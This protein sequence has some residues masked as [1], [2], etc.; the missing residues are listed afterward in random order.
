MRRSILFLIVFIS[1]S[2]SVCAT[3]LVGLR[4]YTREISFTGFTR[5]V[6]EMTIA[7]EISGKC[8][9]VVVDV[10]DAVGPSGVVAEIDS[11]FVRL[12]LEKNKIAQE[13]TKLQLA[14]ANKTLAR[15]KNLINKNSTAQATY[16][17]TALNAEVLALNVKN[18]KNEQERLTEQLKRYTLHAPVGWKVIERRVEPGEYVRPGEE[19]FR[20]GNFQSLL[21]P[22]LFSYEEL[23]LVQQMDKL[24]LYLPDLPDLPNSTRRVETKMYRIAPDF[25]EN[26]RKIAVDML[27][28][29]EAMASHSA[30]RGGLR[31]QLTIEG[32]KEQHSFLI[33][34]TALI[35][36]Y[37]AHWLLSA[38]RKQQKVILLGLTGDEKDAIVSGDD[39]TADAL[40]VT[41]PASTSEKQ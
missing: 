37:D 30:L 14:L 33:P 25:E 11:T 39:L 1:I 9:T 23:S 24:T 4:P 19:L 21:I 36:R 15:F 28:A 5:P 17:E 16:D 6:K 10:G 22:F 26:N 13:Q 31:A 40:F 38:D 35:S 2:S 8:T 29:G 20:L 12:D 41:N 18:L 3:E 7:P 27:V 34:V 32:K